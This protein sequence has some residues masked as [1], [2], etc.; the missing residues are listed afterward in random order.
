MKQRRWCSDGGSIPPIST[1][2][3]LTVE[4]QKPNDSAYEVSE[5]RAQV[6]G[7]HWLRRAQEL[8]WTAGEATRRVQ[9]GVRSGQPT[10]QER[11]NQYPPTT[12]NTARPSKPP[13]P[14]QAHFVT[15]RATV[16]ARYG[17][18]TFKKADL[19]ALMETQPS[20]GLP[21]PVPSG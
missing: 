6:M 5:L 13:D 8:K 11:K 21:K 19:A 16:P 9:Y 12:A 15:E 2:C 10:M 20:Q 4:G 17:A 18:G 3:A 7:M 14:K 1:T